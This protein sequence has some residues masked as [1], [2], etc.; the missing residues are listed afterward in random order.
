ARYRDQFGWLLR[1]APVL[2]QRPFGSLALATPQVNFAQCLPARGERRIEGYGL[3]VSLGREVRLV[4]G[5]VDMAFLLEGASVAGLCRPEPGQRL[6]RLVML[7]EI[8]L[9]NGQHVKRIT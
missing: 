4:A 3:L 1:Q 7:L 2:R 5:Q 9:A 6:Q 8:A